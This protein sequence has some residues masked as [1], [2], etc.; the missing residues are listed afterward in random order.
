MQLNYRAQKIL[1]FV[2]VVL[3]E[4]NSWGIEKSQH[5]L[6]CTSE[7]GKKSC[8]LGVESH[9]NI[10]PNNQHYLVQVIS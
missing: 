7:F 2:Y 9:I 10:T 4:H 3:F 8:D 1:V 5:I 6:Y